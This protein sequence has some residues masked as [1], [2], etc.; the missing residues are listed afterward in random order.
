M[1]PTRGR[2]PFDQRIYSLLDLLGSKYMGTKVSVYL[3]LEALQLIT[4]NPQVLRRPTS[5]DLVIF[6]VSCT[7][8]TLG[9]QYMRSTIHIVKATLSWGTIAPVLD[10]GRAISEKFRGCGTD[11]LPR[12]DGDN[13]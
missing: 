2:S 1:A 11:P 3:G 8:W 7:V 9:I 10:T 12:E 4:W 5:R 6:L 13:A